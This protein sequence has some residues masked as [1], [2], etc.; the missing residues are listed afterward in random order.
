MLREISV[1]N[2]DTFEGVGVNGWGWN[3]IPCHGLPSRQYLLP[4]HV[5]IIFNLFVIRFVVYVWVNAKKSAYMRL[6]GEIYWHKIERE[7]KEKA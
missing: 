1:I 2:I 7:L 4:K 3:S 6:L 5:T